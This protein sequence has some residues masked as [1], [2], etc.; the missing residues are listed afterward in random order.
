M[1]QGANTGCALNIDLENNVMSG[2]TF[3]FDLRPAGSVQRAINVCPFEKLAAANHFFEHFSRN[4]MIFP[5]VLFAFARLASSVGYRITNT[6]HRLQYAID[7]GAFA[8]PRR[9]TDYD[10]HSTPDRRDRGF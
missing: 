9:R 1:N 2:S 8:A 5:T 10:Q 6:G 7:Q 4:E 3:S